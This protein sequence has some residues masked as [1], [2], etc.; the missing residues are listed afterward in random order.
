MRLDLKNIEFSKIDKQRGIKLPLFLDSKLAEDIGIQIGDGCI[1]KGKKDYIINCSFN[2]NEDLQYMQNFVVTLK[3]KLFKN[4][5]LISSKIGGEVR[6]KIGS[7]AV[8]DFYTKII[9]LPAGSKNEV[10]IPKIIFENRDH[11]ISCTRGIMDTDFSLSFKKKHKQV[12]YYPVISANFKSKKLVKQLE[13]IFN[14]LGFKVHAE[15]DY[16]RF[17][18]RFGK[19]ITHYIYLNGKNNLERWWKIIGSNNP[20]LITKYKI[21]K[22]SGS[23]PPKTNVKERFE[24]LNGK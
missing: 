16:E 18:R 5:N 17:D 13:L 20:R 24:I 12:H 10:E 9:G 21:F 8:F 23:C 11:L 2:A 19:V 1:S 15:F 3:T 14:K 7:R 4:A 22:K 6:I